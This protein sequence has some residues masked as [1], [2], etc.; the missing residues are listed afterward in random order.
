LVADAARRADPVAV[1][2]AANQLLTPLVRDDVR[3]TLAGCA[4]QGAE[5]VAIEVDDVRR[6]VEPLTK[7]TQRIV[8][9]PAAH[10]GQ[11]AG[12]A[13]LHGIHDR[14]LGFGPRDIVRHYG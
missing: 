12:A 13:R 2:P 6:E 1:V 9:V 7:R 5:G 8:R 14:I 3:D 10:G 4:R 11:L